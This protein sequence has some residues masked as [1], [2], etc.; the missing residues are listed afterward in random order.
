MTGKARRVWSGDEYSD[1]DDVV[2]VEATRF[3]EPPVEVQGE[4][5][6]WIKPGPRP[7]GWREDGKYGTD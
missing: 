7:K 1:D 4:A 2:L 5:W 3:D 6:G